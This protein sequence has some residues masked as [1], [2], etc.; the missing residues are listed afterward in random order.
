MVIP[1]R[2]VYQHTH[3]HTLAHI[4]Q[5]AA[6]TAENDNVSLTKQV[7]DLSGSLEAAIATFDQLQSDGYQDT[8]ER[9]ELISEYLK[10]T[11]M[12]KDREEGLNTARK[13][14]SAALDEK[15]RYI[16]LAK[17]Q[18]ESYTDGTVAALSKLAQ[19]FDASESTLRQQFGIS[20]EYE[21]VIE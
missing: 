15:R 19:T 5:D 3:I 10:L 7:A 9:Q 8:L 13:S 2:S 12:V 16:A 18:V 4:P 21:D 1:E 14:G 11:S 20:D 17:A 6:K